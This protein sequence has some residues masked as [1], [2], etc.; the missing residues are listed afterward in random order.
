[1]KIQEFGNLGMKFLYSLLNIKQFAIQDF[2]SNFQILE[3]P[4]F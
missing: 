2:F 3:F 1:M 4:N